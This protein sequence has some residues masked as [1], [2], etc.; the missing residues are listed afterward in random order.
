[1]WLYE[2]VAQAPAQ[3]PATTGWI[4]FGGSLVAVAGILLNF[5]K[6]SN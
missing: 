5:L 3:V 4:I 2:L 6:R 1:M